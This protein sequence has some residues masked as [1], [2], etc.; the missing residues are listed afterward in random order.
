MTLLFLLKGYCQL[1][2]IYESNNGSLLVVKNDSVAYRLLNEGGLIS[3]NYGFGV[4][5]IKKNNVLI[6][7]RCDD[8]RKFSAKVEIRKDVIEDHHFRITLLN[9]ELNDVSNY[10]ILID[11]VED[12]KFEGVLDKQGNICVDLKKHPYLL[13][14]NF[15][16]KVVSLVFETSINIKIRD[17][18]SYNIYSFID[19]NFPFSYLQKNKYIFRIEKLSQDFLILKDEC[20]QLHFFKKK[21][22]SFSENTFIRNYI[23]KKNDY[24]PSL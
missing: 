10:I 5:E 6:I 14:N 3:Y 11:S 21:M 7:N 1:N 20:N 19:T 15:I 2:G 13:N 18:F 16:L 24:A 12:I 23:L 9:N 4:F 17:G 8:F 22:Y